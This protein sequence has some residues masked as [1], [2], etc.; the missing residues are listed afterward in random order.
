L[1]NEWPKLALP[2][3]QAL[4]L[5]TEK[6]VEDSVANWLNDAAK[7]QPVWVKH[8]LSQWESEGVADRLIKR[9]GRSLK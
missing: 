8:L 3:L 5:D 1:F 7:D 6:Y 4:K 2:I 9:A